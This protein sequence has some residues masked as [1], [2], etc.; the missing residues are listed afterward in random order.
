MKILRLYIREF[1]ALKD[2]SA[3]LSGGLNLFYGNN[4]SGKSTV[5][6]FI[7]FIF[8]GLP[9]KRGEDAARMRDAAIS[10]DGSAADGYID[11]CACGGEYR[12]ERRGT[13]SGENY[14]ERHSIIDLSTGSA[15]FRGEAPSKV[16]LGGASAAVFDSSCSMRQLG[17]SAVDGGELGSA[18]ENLL[19]SADEQTNTGRA[20]SKLEAARRQLK[21]LRGSGGKVNELERERAIL[22][23]R[24]EKAERD[25]SSRIALEATVEKYRALSAS[26]RHSLTLAQDKCRAYDT[27]QVLNRF[28]ML[29]AGEKK[30]AALR[31]EE[32][33]LAESEGKNGVLPDREYINTLDSI[34]RRLTAAESAVCSCAAKLAELHATHS[35]GDA[36]LA[37]HAEGIAENGG[38]SRVTAHFSALRRRRAFLAVIGALLLL[39][40]VLAAAFSLVVY[41]AHPAFLPSLAPK[42]SSAIT[43]GGFIAAIVGAGLFPIAARQGK[44]AKRYIFSFG[45]D[46]EN[47]FGKA[48]ISEY[49]DSCIN[50]SRDLEASSAIFRGTESELAD[51]REDAAQ[52]Y[53]EALSE[54]RKFADPTDE[55]DIGKLLVSTADRAAISVSKHEII[56]RD[57]DKYSAAIA[58]RREQ[59]S[60]Y[61]EATLRAHLNPDAASI[62][63]NANPTALKQERDAL[64]AR[65]E[66]SVARLHEAE[67]GLAFNDGAAENPVR[68]AAQLEITKEALAAATK[69]HD[70]IVLALSSIE[71]AGELLRRS[72]TPR[73]REAAGA[74]LSDVTNTRYSDIGI[75]EG[76][77][78]TVRTPSGT[79]SVSSLS[80]GTQDAVYFSLRIA[81]LEMLFPKE[82]PPIM[83]DETLSQIDDG[84]AEA[85]LAIISKLCREKDRQCL[86]FSCHKREEE[87]LGAANEDF[88]LKKM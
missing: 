34:S 39:S 54:L 84:R 70:A 79:K 5:L 52:I 7:R 27:I 69:Q 31:E 49:L 56:L 13:L 67:R 74:L 82:K 46:G 28:D 10:W 45:Y 14:T 6:A 83:L 40:G 73:L 30:I 3:E 81:L 76:F 22:A 8:Y 4:E 47:G 72:V 60:D 11:L 20:V 32:A 25:S 63:E 21:P 18:I 37:A 58:E 33:R 29:H 12:I 2:F 59:L 65:L 86:L 41:F 16:F 48:A 44:A 66:A 9:P 85:I 57:I 23:E 53:S 51:L 55:D 61:D 26:L 42:V 43:V 35:L 77:A 75:D 80:R 36:R 17:V 68:I 1:G 71:G 19:F 62:L 15:A 64:A 78:V 38:I 88:T 87:L 24:L 50:A